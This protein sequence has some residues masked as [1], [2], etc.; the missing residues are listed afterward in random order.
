MAKRIKS[1]SS[2]VSQVESKNDSSDTCTCNNI[3]ILSFS[4]MIAAFH[5]KQFKQLILKFIKQVEKD[6]NCSSSDLINIWNGLTTEYNI[7]DDIQHNHMKSSITGHTNN[8][9]ECIYYYPRLNKKCDGTVSDKSITQ[10]YCTKHLK[11]EK[12]DNKSSSTQLST[13]DTCIHQFIRGPNVGKLCGLKAKVG[14]YCG[15]HIKNNE[16][17]KSVTS[18]PKSSKNTENKEIAPLTPRLNKELNIYIDNATGFII[19]KESRKIYARLRNNEITALT[20]DDKQ[21]LDNNKY[22]YDTIMLNK[23]KKITEAKNNNDEKYKS[24]EDEKQKEESEEDDD[25]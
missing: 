20:N 8:A 10:S 9:T 25:L 16:Q 23:N 21:L 4:T 1:G 15:R 12:D 2:S 6:K 11:H 5:E 22:E 24:D 19:D 13:T 17:S 7:T 14:N 18:T 3:N